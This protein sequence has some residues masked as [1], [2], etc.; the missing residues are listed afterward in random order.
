[1]EKGQTHLNARSKQGPANI[2][3]NNHD[4][5][6]KS[7]KYVFLLCS[8]I[9]VL[10]LLLIAIFIFKDSFGF[11][12]RIGVGEFLFND[13]WAPMDDP[14]N[15]GILPMVLGS[16]II[17]ALSCAGAVPIAIMVASYMAFDC[18]QRI[19]N[20]L[21]PSLNLMTGI[22]SIVYGF[23]ALTV[24]VPLMRECFGGDGMNML[25]ASILLLIMILPTITT[26]TETALRSVPACFYQGS[27]ALG[28]THDVTV[29]RV[30]IPAA[31][32]G[33]FAGVILGI[34]RAIGETMAVI[35]VAGNQTRLTLNPLKGI[36]TMT[37]NIIM[38]MS[39]A[40]GEHRDALIATAAVLFIFIL[41]IN[42][43]L[44]YLKNKGK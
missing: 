3:R 24:I 31:K 20:I 30:M 36:R 43:S 44:F 17:T 32:S 4:A 6:E 9:S 34:G 27:R 41:F 19:Y 12:C 39:Y 29:L 35:L 28:A 11:I 18:P 5:Q 14:P 22:P 38:E 42:I 13:T 15:Y 23:F 37:T 21:K 25:S 33:I 16:I 7:A 8:V 10:L 40:A 26:M 1:M 2:C